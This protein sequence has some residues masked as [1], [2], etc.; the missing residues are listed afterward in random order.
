M[1]RDTMKYLFHD[2][3]KEHIPPLVMRVVQGIFNMF[4]TYYVIKY[5]PLVYVSLV[6][7]IAP[8]LIALFGFLLYREKLTVMDTC[9]LIVSFFGVSVLITGSAE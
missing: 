6:T 7:N 3:P 9:I 8:L 2:I 4:C 5:F 1:N